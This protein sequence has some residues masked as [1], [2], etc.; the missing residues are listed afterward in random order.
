MKNKVVWLMC[1]NTASIYVIF[2]NKKISWLNLPLFHN[3]FVCRNVSR[4][5]KVIKFIF[6]LLIISIRFSLEF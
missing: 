5:A 4:P 2:N 3:I 1:L 6:I